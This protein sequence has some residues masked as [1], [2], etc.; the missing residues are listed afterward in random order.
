MQIKFKIVLVL[1]VVVL[2]FPLTSVYALK[3]DASDSSS[4][5]V[6]TSEHME[7]VG[8]FEGLSK[9]KCFE[10]G[11]CYTGRNFFGTLFTQCP[12]GPKVFRFKI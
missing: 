7:V 5:C 4:N 9:K 3:E 2:S 8:Y 1:I 10:Q 12:G 6:V 11:G